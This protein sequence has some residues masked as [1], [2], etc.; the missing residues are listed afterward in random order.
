MSNRRDQ[1]VLEVEKY[2]IDISKIEPEL[3]L[4]LLLNV[5]KNHIG[6]LSFAMVLGIA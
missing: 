1:D 6:G 3:E 5:K 4:W 2:V